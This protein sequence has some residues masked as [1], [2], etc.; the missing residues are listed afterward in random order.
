M[1]AGR[2][3][4]AHQPD[5]RRIDAVADGERAAVA[6]P[7]GLIA[8]R[9]RVAVVDIGQIEQV[10]EVEA[11]DIAA[12]ASGVMQL[13]R[14]GDRGIEGDVLVCKRRS[15]N[16]SLKRPVSTSVNAGVKMRRWAGAKMHQTG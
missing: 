4:L 10:I 16:P 11:G 2:I 12:E 6:I 3:V 5:L 14:A 13:E 1:E 15:K 8:Q 9:E 7:I